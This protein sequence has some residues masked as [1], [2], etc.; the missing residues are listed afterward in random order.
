VAV[1]DERSE[2]R[3]EQRRNAPRLGDDPDEKKR[4]KLLNQRQEAARLV[5]IRLTNMNPMKKDWQGEI[6][7]VSNSVVGT[8][9]KYVPFNAEEGWHVPNIIFQALKAR[10]CQIFVN[11]RD[12]RGNAVKRS[13]QVPEFA[14]EEL[15]PLS[16]AELQEL[17]QRQ[18]MA[19]STAN[20]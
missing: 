9:R 8:F 7:T 18:A 1:K 6:I 19:G 17:A 11:G 2:E 16:P 3:L 20:A 15:D 13:K 14:I 4:E 10:Q 12:D 5:R